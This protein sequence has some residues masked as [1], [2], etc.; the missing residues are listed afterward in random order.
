MAYEPIAYQAEGQ[1]G[2][3][4]VDHEGERINCFSNNLTSNQSNEL[5]VKKYWHEIINFWFFKLALF[6]IRGLMLIDP[7]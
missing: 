6:A 5:R 2:Y 4:L 1:M 3:W 7:L